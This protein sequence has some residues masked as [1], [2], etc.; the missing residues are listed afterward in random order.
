MTIAD[1]KRHCL[2][3]GVMAATLALPLLLSTPAHA[4]Q[5]RQP[6]PEQRYVVTNVASSDV[7]NIRTQPD[8]TAEIL[9][10]LPPDA[11]D[12][13]VAGTSHESG[14]QT[15][16]QVV[17]PKGTGWVNASYLAP[18]G[19]NTTRETAF[20]LRCSG[21]EPFWGVNIADGKAS[22]ST[23]ESS[24]AFTASPMEWARGSLRH[25][26]VR[27]KMGEASGQLTVLRA[28]PACS[29]GMSDTA[30]PYE[31]VLVKPDGT[32]LSGCCQRAG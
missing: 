1:T 25:F 23:P 11:K 14:S 29:D 27:L 21:T 7:L 9:T 28:S 19:D 3:T 15:W 20:P 32:V 10:S 24:E 22:F 4:G 12:I 26:I 8:A 18:S 30:F 2:F 31:G 17:T 16:W 6:V 13:I 5:D